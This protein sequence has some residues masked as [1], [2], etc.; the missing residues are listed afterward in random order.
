MSR[1]PLS[2]CGTLNY[3]T[4]ILEPTELKH[5]FAFQPKL[6]SLLL[7]I[8]NM[9]ETVL[10]IYNIKQCVQSRNRAQEVLCSKLHRH[11]SL[12]LMMNQLKNM[13]GK[14]LQL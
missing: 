11:I 12:P 2:P 13:Y 10:V 9:Y 3:D 1:G 8:L 14:H 5:Q 7:L 4:G 6:I